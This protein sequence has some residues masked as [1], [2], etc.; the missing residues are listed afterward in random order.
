[1][2]FLLGVSPLVSPPAEAISFAAVIVDRYTAY[3]GD[4]ITWRVYN[5]FGLGPFSYRYDIYID[6]SLFSSDSFHFGQSQK[7]YTAFMPGIYSVSIT[8]FDNNDS[9]W[10]KLASAG[11]IVSNRAAPKI[12]KVEALSGT[13]LKVTWTK[14][15][16]ATGYILL[17]STSK[18]GTYSKIK[19]TT[20]TSFTD[21]GLTAG[22]AYYYK[23][24]CYNL[25]GIGTWVSS[26]Y[27]AIKAGVPLAKSAITGATGVSTTQIKLTW[28]KVTGATGYQV[29]RSATAS[30]TYK[31]IKTTTALSLT[32]G[33]MLHAKTYYF[34]VRPYKAFGTV[35]YYGPLSA[36]RVGKTK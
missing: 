26:D 4:T 17:R 30:G 15:A 27:S 7:S 36:Y 12:T 35:K 20:A 16:G 18:T 25:I 6:G 31:L 14:V 29:F 19:T 5:E 3:V 34:K 22:K 21:T 28:K 10:Y 33:G 1:M 9:T 24:Q 32:A 2:I 13:S 23:V 8:V 11:T